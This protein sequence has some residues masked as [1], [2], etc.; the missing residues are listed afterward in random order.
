MNKLEADIQKETAQ[1]IMSA[2]YSM[3]QNREA[4]AKKSQIHFLRNRSI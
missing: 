1:V 4:V 3:L 2:S